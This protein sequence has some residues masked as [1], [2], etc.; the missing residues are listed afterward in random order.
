VPSLI[1]IYHVRELENAIER[2]IIL[3]SDDSILPE[4][5]PEALLESSSAA[6]SKGSYYDVVLQF[7]RD[8]ILRT[9]HQLDGNYK[10]AA[11]ALG[12]HVNNLHRLIRNLNLKSKI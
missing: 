6:S 3:G 9:I 11:K 2:A 1:D 4:D 8:V 12:I 10:E 7:K 5:L